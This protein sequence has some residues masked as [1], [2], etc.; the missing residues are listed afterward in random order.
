[1]NSEDLP[2]ARSRPMPQT[3]LE[4]TQKTLEKLDNAKCIYRC[5]DPLVISPI[6]IVSENGA[7]KRLVVDQRALNKVVE[8][9]SWTVPHPEGAVNQLSSHKVWAKIDLKNGY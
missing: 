4:F 7:P 3:H 5:S 9:Y 1:V 8:R 2:R 6:V